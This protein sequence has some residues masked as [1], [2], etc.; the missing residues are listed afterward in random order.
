MSQG[1]DEKRL[2]RVGR[3]DFENRKPEFER[4]RRIQLRP[5]QAEPVGE[6]KLPGDALE[7]ILAGALTVGIGTAL[8]YD[9]LVVKRIKRGIAAYLDRAGFASVADLVGKLELN[10]A[11]DKAVSG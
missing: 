10:E 6:G 4:D 8:F 5:W 9:P 2:A 11:L 3:I 1:L 7:F